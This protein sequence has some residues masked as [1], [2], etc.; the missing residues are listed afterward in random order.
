MLVAK[1]TEQLKQKGVENTY[2][3]GTCT[4][5]TGESGLLLIHAGAV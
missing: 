1:A 4:D 5:I 2:A 3:P